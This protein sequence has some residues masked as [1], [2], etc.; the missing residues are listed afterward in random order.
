MLSTWTTPRNRSTAPGSTVALISMYGDGT[1]SGKSRSNSL[2]VRDGAR[3]R[4]PSRPFKRLI[5]SRTEAE[6]GRAMMLR[7]PS[8]R[9]AD[10][11]LTLEPPKDQGLL[12]EMA[13]ELGRAELRNNLALVVQE[14]AHLGGLKAAS[15]E[16]ITRRR[17]RHLLR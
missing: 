1:E 13:G 12:G 9:G 7:L 16:R 14:S 2:A 5:R 17:D 4:H 8:A 15:Q 6:S 10:L 11:A 3:G